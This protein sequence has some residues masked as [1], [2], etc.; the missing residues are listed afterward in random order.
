MW[1]SPH[2]LTVGVTW[3]VSSDRLYTFDIIDNA[4]GG[5]SHVETQ[6]FTIYHEVKNASPMY[7][8]DA[9]VPC[10]RAPMISRVEFVGGRA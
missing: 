9:F 10:V 8:D 2:K 1:S 6:D 4:A 3:E 5:W 7:C